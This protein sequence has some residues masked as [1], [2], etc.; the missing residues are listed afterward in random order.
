MKNMLNNYTNWIKSCSWFLQTLE[1]ITLN[2][3]VGL[4]NSESVSCKTVEECTQLFVKQKIKH[5]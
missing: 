4:K 5:I 2:D 1:S 3:S